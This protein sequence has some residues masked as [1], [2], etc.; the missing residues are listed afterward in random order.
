MTIG[1][2]A[3]KSAVPASTI[4][5]WERVGVLPAPARVS[6]QRRY[7]IDAL[8]RLA[9]LRLAQSCGF[10]L[11]EMRHLLLGFRP[12]ITASR[13]WQELA[14]QKQKE[15]DTQIAQLQEMR[16]LVDQLSSCRCLDLAECGRR[17]ASASHLR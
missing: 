10:R 17:A 3:A 13:R 6:G 15:L 5:Y 14:I 1:E 4:R 11:D 8:H 7:P 16:R 12:E 2:L 9:L